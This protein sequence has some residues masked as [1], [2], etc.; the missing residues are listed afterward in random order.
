MNSPSTTES[1]AGTGVAGLDEILGGG[2]PRG[3]V[4][5]LEGPPGTGKTTLALQF[6]LTGV[7]RQEPV[8]YVTLS[9][10]ATELRAVA[11]S[12]GWALD[13]VDVLEVA[14]VEP[15]PPPE[16]DPQYTLFHPAEVELSPTLDLI[17]QRVEAVKPTR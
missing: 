15:G 2:L 13:G 5:L 17:R 6:L 8:V 9:E 10:T 3:R 11:E 1:R 16:G 4:Y 12:H 7:A 14:V